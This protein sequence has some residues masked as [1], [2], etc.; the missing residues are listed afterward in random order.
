[1]S[2]VSIWLSDFMMLLAQASDLATGRSRGFALRSCVLALRIARLAGLDEQ[3]QRNAYHLARLR[4]VGCNADT[5]LMAGL[6]GEE[7]ALRQCL[8]GLDIRDRSELGRV[9]MQAFKRLCFGVEAGLG[10][11]AMAMEESKRSL[12]SIAPGNRP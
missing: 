12:M 9:F 11:L 10:Q 6:F 4:Y 3:L 7:I 8:V 1:M 5:H 2:D